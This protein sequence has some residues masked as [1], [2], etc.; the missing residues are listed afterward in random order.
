MGW[1]A[2]A[3]ILS[4]RRGAGSSTGA[5]NFFV[6]CPRLLRSGSPSRMVNF[7]VVASVVDFR[8]AFSGHATAPRGGTDTRSVIRQQSEP[9]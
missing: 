6:Q 8:V 7:G 1:L 5:G 2:R 4:R 3:Q 9:R